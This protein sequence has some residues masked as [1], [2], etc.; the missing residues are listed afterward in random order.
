ML[1]PPSSEPRLPFSSPHLSR[2]PSAAQDKPG[3]NPQLA[4]KPLNARVEALLKK[5]T[6]EEKIGQLVQFS[7][8]FATGPKPRPRNNQR[9]DD[10]VAKGQVG[11]FFNVVGAEA[12]N[13]YQHIA[14]EKTPPAHPAHLRARRHPRRPHHLS[15]PAGRGGQLRS[16]RRRR[17]WR[18]PAA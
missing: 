18:A 9:F 10:L 13:H 14:M 4:A 12:T 7:A 8:G 11:S 2:F 1:S 17:S 5:M 16:R 15:R 6:L 3:P